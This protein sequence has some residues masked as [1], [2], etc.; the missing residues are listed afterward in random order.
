MG[1]AWAH[2]VRAQHTSARGPARG[3]GAVLAMKTLIIHSER[4]FSA[5]NTILS[6]LPAYSLHVR[7]KLAIAHSNN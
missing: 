2:P 6:V 3:P 7:M 4:L 5:T 1:T